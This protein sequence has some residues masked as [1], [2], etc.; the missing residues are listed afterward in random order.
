MVDRS[1]EFRKTEISLVHR[2]DTHTVVGGNN[3]H[4]S[5]I[6]M[7]CDGIRM[8]SYPVLNFS[9]APWFL[10]QNRILTTPL[11]R[12]VAP[13]VTVEDVTRVAWYTA[14]RH[15]QLD[16]VPRCPATIVHGCGISK[17]KPQTVIDRLTG[18]ETAMEV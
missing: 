12:Q 1:L 13:I 3:A 15:G 8:A 17:D 10:G 5:Q 7:S 6:G 9:A 11:G 2:V 14:G 18:I 16:P 4:I